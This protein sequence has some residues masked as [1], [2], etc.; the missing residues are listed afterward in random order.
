MNI[1]PC[2]LAC[3]TRRVNCRDRVVLSNEHVGSSVNG[4][5][6][7]GAIG[8]LVGTS[9]PMGGTGITVLN[10]AFGRGYPSAEGAGV[11]SVC[12]RLHRCKVAPMVTSPRTSTSRT[13]HLCKVRFVG[14]GSVGGYSTM[15]LTITRRRFGSL[16][17][18][19]FRTVFG[20]DRGGGIL[21]SVGKLLSHGGCRGTKCVC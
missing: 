21:I 9:I 3:G 14:V 17:V 18:G 12:G 4:C 8:G 16:A 11:V 19:S 6:T 15:V 13:G 5:M 10:F 20:R 1:S 2:C 7:R